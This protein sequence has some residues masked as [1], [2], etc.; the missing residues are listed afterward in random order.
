MG[1]KYEVRVPHMYI[2]FV[3]SD[4]HIPVF[5]FLRKR[6]AFFIKGLFYASVLVFYC[7]CFYFVL[8]FVISL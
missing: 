3:L 1:T 4:V 5:N 2:N 6:T 7:V 8:C